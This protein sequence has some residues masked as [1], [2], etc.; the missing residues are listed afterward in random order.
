MPP[1]YGGIDKDMT[2]EFE[3]VRADGI[4]TE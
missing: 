3:E 2:S 1:V 4:T